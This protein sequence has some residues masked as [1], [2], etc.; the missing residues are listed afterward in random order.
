MSLFSATNQK[1]PSEQLHKLAN[2]L[3][4]RFFLSKGG[5]GQGYAGCFCHFDVISET[6]QSCV[7]LHNKT[8]FR[9]PNS[10][11]C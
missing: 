3:L 11:I 1:R 9:R 2:L 8:I 7:K 5:R 10:V 4:L 6:W